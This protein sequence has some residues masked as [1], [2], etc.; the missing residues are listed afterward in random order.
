MPLEYG[1]TKGSA[2]DEGHADKDER[3]IYETQLLGPRYKT[4]STK[5]FQ[6]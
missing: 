5:V 3:H 1:I 2:A 6:S 4:D